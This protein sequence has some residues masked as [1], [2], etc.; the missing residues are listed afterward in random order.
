MA[1]DTE[2]ADG[3]RNA[4]DTLR[5]VRDANVQAILAQTTFEDDE[6]VYD[7]MAGGNDVA[8]DVNI[9]DLFLVGMLLQ[10]GMQDPQRGPMFRVH[11]LDLLIRLYDSHA[12]DIADAI[13]DEDHAHLGALVVGPDADDGDPSNPG[14][15]YQ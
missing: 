6:D 7:A 4:V 13:E 9:G 15:M 1:D 11:A 2:P 14:G 12:D 10:E 8:L 3:I 5:E